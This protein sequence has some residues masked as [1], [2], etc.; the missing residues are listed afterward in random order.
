MFTGNINDFIVEDIS[1]VDSKKFYIQLATYKDTSNIEK[2][3]I[4][5]SDKY[6]LALVKAPT[7]ANAY[8]VVIGPLTSDEYTVVLER[9]KSYGYKD[10]FLRIASQ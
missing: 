2:V 10:A 4:N 8:Q 1:M 6:P 3:L 9:F 7:I 5:Y